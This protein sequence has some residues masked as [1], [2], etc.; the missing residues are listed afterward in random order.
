MIRVQRACGL[1]SSNPNDVDHRY[2]GRCHVFHLDEEQKQAEGL[3]SI[4]FDGG[5]SQ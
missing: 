5:P 3:M 4:T 1:E 2:C